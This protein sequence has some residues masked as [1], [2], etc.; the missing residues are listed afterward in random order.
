MKIPFSPPFI[1]QAVIDSVMDTLRSKWITSGPK[2][3]ELEQEMLN[4]TGSR[5]AICVNSWTSGAIMMLKWFGVK[6]G[7]EV[8]VPAYSYCATALCVLHAG[9]KP[10]MVD[11]LDDFTI[12]PI[13]VRYAITERTKAILAVDIA[14]WPCNYN[15]LNAVIKDSAVTKMFYPETENQLKLGRI[16]LISDAAHSIGATYGGVPAAQKSDIAIFSFHAVKNVTTAEGGC[17][18][19]NLTDNF[20]V[21][22][23]YTY[24]KMYSLNGQTKD[25]FTKTMGS[26]WRYDILFNGLKI[27]MPDICAAIGLAQLRQYKDLLLPVRKKIAYKYNNTF[28]LFSWFVPPPLSNDERE[29][30]YHLFPLRIRDITE[31]G[32][33]QII[34]YLSG[35]GITANVHFIPMPMLTYFKSIG[36]DIQDYPNSYRQYACEISLPIYPQLTNAEIDYIIVNV[37]N[38]VKEQIYKT[39]MLKKAS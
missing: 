32:R 16:L 23:E 8:I 15:L 7:D 26:G 33:D 31:E 30:S 14:G 27:N 34:E 6:E 38:A 3:K 18:C 36:Y 21:A 37:A 11:V 22:E 10:V 9:A 19:L 1:D 4:L 13:K 24:L 39:K 35:K 12:D 17:I 20:N 2:V 25:A 28:S 29:S 5:A